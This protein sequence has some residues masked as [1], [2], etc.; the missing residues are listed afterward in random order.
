MASSNWRLSARRRVDP[1][2]GSV[3]SARLQVG[4]LWIDRVGI[5]DDQLPVIVNGDSHR[6]NQVFP[7]RDHSLVA[8]LRVHMGHLPGSEVLVLPLEAGHIDIVAIYGNPK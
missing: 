3:V 7:L 6:A 5:G 4:T 2:N 8:G 1:D